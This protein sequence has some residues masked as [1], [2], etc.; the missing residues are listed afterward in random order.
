RVVGP[1]RRNRADVQPG[2]ETS[3]GAIETVVALADL[4]EHPLDVPFRPR[5]PDA[6]P[7]GK[8]RRPP[9]WITP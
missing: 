7:R 8:V 1:G 6:D 3:M 2:T 9:A 5:T 4:L